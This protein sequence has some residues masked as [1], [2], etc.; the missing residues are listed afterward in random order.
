M[1]AA[2]ESS[3]RAGRSSPPFSS[4]PGSASGSRDCPLSPESTS[5]DSNCFLPSAASAAASSTVPCSGSPSRILSKA[6]AFP[7]LFSSPEAF[8]RSERCSSSVRIY[9]VSSRFLRIFSSIS[10]IC[11][12]LA[13]SVSRRFFFRASFAALTSRFA[14]PV[15]SIL[16]R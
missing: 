3:T 9:S 2:K 7:K 8:R 15:C 6:G 5:V 11:F 10:A 12:T 13:A 14:S 4:S 16:T 1:P